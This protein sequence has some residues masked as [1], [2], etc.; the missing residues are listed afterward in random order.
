MN[1]YEAQQPTCSC[2]SCWL[3]LLLANKS[4]LEFIVFG[5]GE[6]HGIAWNVAAMTGAYVQPG[7]SLRSCISGPAATSERCG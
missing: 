1:V 2:D 7:I 4:Q 6:S 3:R 5:A